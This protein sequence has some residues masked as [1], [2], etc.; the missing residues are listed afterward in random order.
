MIPWPLPYREFFEWLST[1]PGSEYLRSSIYANPINLTLH[2]LSMCLFLGLLVM[3]DLRLMGIAHTDIPVSHVQRR[4]FPWQMAG[5]TVMVVTGFLLFWADPVRYWGKLFFWVKLFIMFLAGLNALAFHFTT[6]RS[7]AEWDN[8]PVPPRSA[9]LA[10][11]IGIVCWVAVLAFGRLVAYP[12]WWT[13][14]I[15]PRF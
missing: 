10:G 14:E 4:L 13:I 2:V 12:D 11:A 8:D 9:R 7:V 6:Y 1:L 5:V 3:M 15:E